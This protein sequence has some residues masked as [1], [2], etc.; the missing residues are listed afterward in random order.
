MLN[1]LQEMS[2]EKLMVLYQNDDM[3]AFNV[4]YQRYEHIT[5]E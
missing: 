4:L 5:T 3:Y 1:T 2:D